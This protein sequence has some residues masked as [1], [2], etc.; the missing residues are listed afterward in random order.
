MN[1][2]MNVVQLLPCCSS[3][4]QRHSCPES[5]RLL[6]DS[7]FF[8][9]SLLFKH[10]DRKFAPANQVLG[11]HQISRVSLHFFTKVSVIFELETNEKKERESRLL[12]ELASLVVTEFARCARSLSE[13][14]YYC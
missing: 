13:Q 6:G 12:L 5:L 7:N 10:D 14:T 3:R 9:S 8:V 4:T 11:R 1:L 2:K